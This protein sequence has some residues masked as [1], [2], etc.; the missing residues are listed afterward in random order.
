MLFANASLKI[1]HNLHDK[2]AQHLQWQCCAVSCIQGYI[3]KSNITLLV[4]HLHMN[5]SDCP[6]L[7]LSL[8]SCSSLD[9]EYPSDFDCITSTFKQ[10]KLQ[11]ASTAFKLS[12]NGLHAHGQALL[13]NLDGETCPGRLCGRLLAV[14]L[15]RSIFVT[16]VHLLAVA[17]PYLATSL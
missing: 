13:H 16:K 15:S 2:D 6:G 11:M 3:S 1:E 10:F 14:N 17:F 12:C 7:H 9:T 5:K 8:C 4:R